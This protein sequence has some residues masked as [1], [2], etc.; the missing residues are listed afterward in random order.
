M[1]KQKILIVATSRDPLLLSPHA[2]KEGS[3]W[4]RRGNGE[5]PWRSS[6]ET[7]PD[8]SSWTS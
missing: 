1:S 7:K 8:L 3:R 6:E 2:R 5:E 4:S